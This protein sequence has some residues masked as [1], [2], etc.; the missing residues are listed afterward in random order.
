MRVLTCVN[1]G[2][3]Y[4][5]LRDVL[6][7]PCDPK[8]GARRPHSD[9]MSGGD[10]DGDLYWCCWD[11]RLICIDEEKPCLYPPAGNFIANSSYGRSDRKYVELTDFLRFEF[12]S[13]FHHKRIEMVTICGDSRCFVLTLIA[14]GITLSMIVSKKQKMVKSRVIHT[15][16]KFQR[17]YGLF[18]RAKQLFWG[19]ARF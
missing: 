18:L 3:S 12:F 2:V 17:L 10:L 13:V 4:S 5:H 19:A 6:V 8:S 16:A 1:P 9:E 11:P 15:T 7:F 14:D